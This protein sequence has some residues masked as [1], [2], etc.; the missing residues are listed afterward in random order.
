MWLLRAWLWGSREELKST[1][2]KH[3][4]NSA[5][6][7]STGVVCVPAQ[8]QTYLGRDVP[9]DVTVVWDSS[10]RG[11]LGRRAPFFPGQA[12]LRLHVLDRLNHDECSCET[13]ADGPPGLADP[14]QA[15]RLPR[16][17]YETMR[18]MEPETFVRIL[19]KFPRRKSVE[20]ATVAE[21]VRKITTDPILKEKLVPRR[22]SK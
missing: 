13:I 8:P 18:N 16:L 14:G 4:S 2:E 17:T 12:E 20:R 10:H 3:C 15:G 11:L 6:E 7:S 5:L 19:A 9:A 22:F 21:V 1:I